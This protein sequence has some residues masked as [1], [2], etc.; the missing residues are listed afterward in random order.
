MGCSEK[1]IVYFDRA[2]V[3]NTKD[4]FRLAK[5]RMDELGVKKVLIASD[6][7]TSAIVAL[8][9]FKPGEIVVV[10]PMYGLSKPG[11]NTFKEENRAILQKNGATIIHATHVFAGIDRAINRRYGGITHVQLMAQTFKMLGE[12]FKVCMEIASMAAD[13]GA[14]GVEDEVI[15]IGGTV[16]GAD[17]AI[18]I[19][20]SHTNNFFG[21]QIKEIIC[22]PRERCQKPQPL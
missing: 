7:G 1:K 13:C 4:T 16:K 18:V 15:S 22:V 8:D 5:E 2:G 17:T 9:Y 12:G 19:V 6:R 3:A 14:V 21:S 10:A 11:T 20:P